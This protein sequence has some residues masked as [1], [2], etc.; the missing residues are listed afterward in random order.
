M[1]KNN[2]GNAQVCHLLTLVFQ[3]S[4]IGVPFGTS[5]LSH[6]LFLRIHDSRIALHPQVDQKE[7]E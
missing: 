7:V 5:K 6:H 1:S 3:I 2:V 4:H